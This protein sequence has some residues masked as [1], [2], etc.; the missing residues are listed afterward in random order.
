MAERKSEQVTG[1]F[2]AGVKSMLDNKTG[3]DLRPI[4]NKTV[5]DTSKTEA[6]FNFEAPSR[7][8][9]PTYRFGS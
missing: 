4:E 8:T 9:G 3:L 6:L 7:N 5:T 1:Y 2:I